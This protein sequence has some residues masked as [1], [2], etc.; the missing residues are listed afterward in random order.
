MPANWDLYQSVYSGRVEWPTGPMTLTPDFAPRWVE[1]WVV[2]GGGMGPGQDLPGPSQC[3]FQ[4]SP[5]S[6]WGL[7][8]T[9]WT[10]DAPRWING[11]GSFQTGAGLDA[12]LG[13]SLLASRHTVTGDYEFNWWFDVIILY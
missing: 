2:Q 11:N 7:G 1:A 4:S 13:I 12:A 8:S 5:W 9:R 3:T 6:D 10:A